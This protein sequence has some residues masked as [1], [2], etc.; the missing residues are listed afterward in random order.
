MKIKYYGKIFLILFFLILSF[1][2]NNVYAQSDHR[3]LFIASYHPGFPTFFDQVKGLKDAFSGQNIDLDI[4]FMDTKRF[5][6]KDN[7][8]QFSER[9]TFK[10]LNIL[11]YDLI[12]LADDNALLFGLEQQEKLFKGIPIVFLG[13]NNV[14]RALQQNNNPQIT[15]VIEAV[16][17]KETVD[18]MIK[19]QPG[20]NKII[21]IV[22]GTPSGQGDFNTLIS[23]QDYYPNHQFSK[24]DLSVLSW[25]QFE[26][27]LKNIKE[28]ISILLLS[29]YKDS[30]GK[31]L[32]FKESLE[33]IIKSSSVPIYHLW[34]HGIGDGILGGKVI[35]HYNQGKAAGG[36]AL[37]ILKGTSVSDIVVERKSPNQYVFD[38]NVIEKFNISKKN[39]PNN[40]VIIT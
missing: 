5:Q 39:I 36:I 22:D 32:E 27:Q 38:F 11:P 8:E 13:V 1:F 37:N 14:E 2:S 3:V 18:L 20:I 28:T 23:I 21:A 9:L 31:V 24:I 29:A 6:E 15:G 16:S 12:I 35:S 17:I 25:E 34:M 26:S 10:L 40:S 33:I 7:W 4:E 30:D 19:Q